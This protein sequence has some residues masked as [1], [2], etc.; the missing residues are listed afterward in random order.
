MVAGAK[1]PILNPNE[2]DLWK[3]RIEKYFLMTDYSLWEVILNGDSPTPTRIVNGV[4]QVIDPTTAE[5]RLVKKNEL[6]ARGTL[7]MALPDKHQVKF[8]IHKDAKS[9]TEAIKKRFGG[10]KE[11]K[12]D[13]INLKFLRSLP[14]EWKT[15]TLI[16]RNKVDLEEQ[17]LDDLFINLKIYEA[18][19]N[20]SSTSSQNTQNIA[21]VSSNNTDST[22]E[23]VSDV[24]SVSAASSK[25]PSNS[26]QLDNEDLK[27]I[28]ADDLEEIDL[29]WQMVMLTM[30]ARRFLQRTGRNLGAN[31]TAAI[32]FDMSKVE[33]YNCHRRGHFARKCRSSRDNRNKDTPRRTVPIEVSTSNALVSQCSSNSSGSDNELQATSVN[34][35]ARE[36]FFDV[37]LE[38]AARI[39]TD[40]PDTGGGGD[41]R[42]QLLLFTGGIISIPR[43][44]SVGIRGKPRTL[45]LKLKANLTFIVLSSRLLK[46]LI[47]NDR[48]AIRQ[49]IAD[50]I[51]AAW[52]A[53]A[54]TMAN[55]DNPNRNTGPRETHVAKRGNYKE[56]ASC[57]P[58]YLNG[59][60]GVLGLIR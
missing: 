13:D 45:K 53:Q 19:V 21:F 57:Q 35:V 47:S 26:P 48:A 11:T 12:K 49:L 23:S 33:C 3:M 55:T 44:G 31:G 38:I 1:L 54:A 36:K 42:H 5:Q 24:P 40:K 59:T 14:S 16:W 25:A 22:N 30:R 50:G 43:V 41:G 20:G 39:Q 52:E 17:S 15:R 2:F 10:N 9:L 46:T 34:L 18:E 7:L 32:R 28:D 29:K 58:F 56:F 27:Q 4:V 51:A 60:E 8:N 37:Y 6:K